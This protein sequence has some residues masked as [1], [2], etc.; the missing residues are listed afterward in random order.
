MIASGEKKEE[1][2]EFKEY[3]IKRFGYTSYSSSDPSE[4]GYYDSEMWNL[5]DIIKFTNGY[6]KNSPSFYIEVLDWNVAKSN[7]PEWGGNI[8]NIQ[9]IFKLGKILT[10][11]TLKGSNDVVNSP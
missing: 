11:T 8:N 10:G 3:W 2:R 1:Y 9:F 6:S 4:N 5:P 7:H